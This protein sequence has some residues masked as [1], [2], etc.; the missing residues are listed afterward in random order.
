M[1]TTETGMP[2]WARAATAEDQTKVLRTPMTTNTFVYNI[3]AGQIQSNGRHQE[4]A[5]I[6]KAVPLAL[7][8]QK[9]LIG[10][11]RGYEFASDEPGDDHRPDRAIYYTK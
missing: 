5:A 2:D 3:Q 4:Q 8:D 10:S 11:L 7:A 9:I 1:Y 6:L